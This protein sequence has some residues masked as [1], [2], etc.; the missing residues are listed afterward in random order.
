MSV[1]ELCVALG[2]EADTEAGSPNPGRRGREAGEGVPTWNEAEDNT[3]LVLSFDGGPAWVEP[4]PAA[5]FDINGIGVC[6]STDWPT[7]ATPWLAL[8]RDGDGKIDQGGELFGSGTVLSSGRRARH[9][10]EALA[11]L[12]SNGDGR[13]T[14]LDAEFAKLILWSD[15]DIDKRGTPF[16]FESMAMRGIV[17]IELIY[18]SWPECDVRGNCQIERASFTFVDPDGAVQEGRVIDLHLACQ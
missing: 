11:D 16:E 1:P 6:V 13:I 2:C 7:D 12:D 3:P 17:S 5:A 8:D 9:G 18:E 14:K 15:I 4:A 10:F